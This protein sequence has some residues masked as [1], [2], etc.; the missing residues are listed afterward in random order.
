MIKR[1]RG[2]HI[3][4]G[5]TANG[6]LGL[7]VLTGLVSLGRRRKGGQSSHTEPG[8]QCQRRNVS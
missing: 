8:E 3:Q 2:R 5:V 1:R 7:I 6:V 4:V